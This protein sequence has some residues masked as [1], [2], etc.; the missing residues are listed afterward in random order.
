MFNDLLTFASGAQ[1]YWAVAIFA[2]V[3]QVL[4]LVGAFIGGAHDFD[5]GAESHDGSTTDAVKILSLRILTAFFVGFGW[6]GVMGHRNGMSAAT[7]GIAA[8]I[9]G[10]LFMLLLFFT[11]RFLMSLRD[12]GSLRYEN[13]IGLR[14]QVYVTIPAAR[15]GHG[16]IEVMLQGRL[17]TAGAVT[18]ADHDLPPQHG[19]EITA[20][21]PPN[22]FV[23]KP[24]S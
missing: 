11:L 21:T 5:H 3:L 1:L 2:S 20:L 9:T 22:T 23:V 15:A 24:I 12:D 14:G 8:I 19:I 4:L 16:Q 6:A 17:I 10:I 7:T 18:D 13:A